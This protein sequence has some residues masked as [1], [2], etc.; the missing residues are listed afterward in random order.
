[1]FDNKYY[2]DIK[3]DMLANRRTNRKGKL[4]GDEI[5]KFILCYRK[6]EFVYRQHGI[7]RGIYYPMMLIESIRFHKL[8]INCGYSIPLNCFEKGMSLAH[9]GSIVVNG[10]A[11]IGKNCR[12]H[13]GV[14]IG[15]T[16]GNNEAP[17]IG[18]NVFIGTGAK[19]IGNIQIANDVAIGANAVV[20][21]SIDEPG[22]TWAGNPAKKISNKN[23]H[24]LLSPLIFQ[25]KE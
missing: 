4:W 19:I 23:S 9:R 11:K 18:D 2:E 8:S 13:E 15:T 1:M 12:I 25:N 3:M 6:L 21:K 17:V 10:F 20:V 22:T 14:T 24:A 5:W 16:G 7:K